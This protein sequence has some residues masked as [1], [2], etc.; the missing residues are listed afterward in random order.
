MC[1]RVCV[2]VCVCVC[3]WMCLHATV[4]LGPSAVVFVLQGGIYLFVHKRVGWSIC[5]IYEMFFFL[6]ACG[7]GCVHVHALAHVCVHIL[8]QLHR[9]YTV[10]RCVTD[11]AMCL[12]AADAIHI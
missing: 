6:S 4:C 2:C 10:L 1:V 9:E 12:G 11:R 8:P 5:V 3:V 7:W